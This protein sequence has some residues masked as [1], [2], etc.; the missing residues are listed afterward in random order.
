MTQAYPGTGRK[1]RGSKT[2]TRRVEGKLESA[3]DPQI[4]LPTLIQAQAFKRELEMP[5][6]GGSHRA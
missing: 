1:V 2:L 3:G 5:F 6:M 4:I